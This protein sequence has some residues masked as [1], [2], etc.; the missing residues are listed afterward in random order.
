MSYMVIFVLDDL[1][2][3]PEVLSAWEDVGVSG[4]TIIESTGLGRVRRMMGLRDDLPLMPSVMR[5]LQTREE[6]HRTLF[7]VVPEEAD[8]D[9]LIAATE[10][11]VGDLREPNRGFLF[12][13][14]VIRV[15]GGVGL[16]QA[17]GPETE[18][19]DT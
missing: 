11:V 2:R 7:T 1:D 4:I 12:A 13:L 3:S 5:L 16:G 15:A 17:G 14:P 19:T 8:I 6:R 10:A 9:R 18:E